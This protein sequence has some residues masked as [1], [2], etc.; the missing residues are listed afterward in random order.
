MRVEAVRAVVDG[1]AVAEVRVAAVAVGPVLRAVLVLS[2]LRLALP[3]V[4]VGDRRVQRR[5]RA[6]E[7]GHRCG[8]ESAAAELRHDNDY[9]MPK[10]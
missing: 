3:R 5:G 1:A 2:R 6:A 9:G 8:E 7:R 10:P 4:A